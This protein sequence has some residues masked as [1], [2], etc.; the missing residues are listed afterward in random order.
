MRGIDDVVSGYR[1]VIM[2]ACQHVGYNGG[3]GALTQLNMARRKLNN[4]MK[5]TADPESDY[6]TATKILQSVAK[7][8]FQVRNRYIQGYTKLEG[9]SDALLFA[10]RARNRSLITDTRLTLDP[11]KKSDD[12]ARQ[13]FDLC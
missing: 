10:W 9:D 6:Q 5:Y 2:T 8:L 4:F 13:D 7:T 3:I 12:Q 11:M 1:L